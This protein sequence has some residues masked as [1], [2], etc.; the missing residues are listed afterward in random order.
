M[1]AIGDGALVPSRASEHQRVL[2]GI[3]GELTRTLMEV[4]GVASARVHLAVPRQ[5]PLEDGA[6][7]PPSASVL[8]RHRGAQSPIA[9]DD[10]KKLVTFAVPGLSPDR[11]FVATIAAV[12][13]PPR[14]LERF[15][16]LTTTRVVAQRLRLMALGLA[17]LGLALAG[18]LLYLW[19][20]ARTAR[21]SRRRIAALS[22]RSAALQDPAPRGRL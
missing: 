10:V 15:G 21:R 5:G 7:T 19:S 11:V 1:D 3:A 8:I 12:S 22:A 4:D 2:A 14:D 16:P 6:T 9:T 17:L 20:R 13:P 18:S